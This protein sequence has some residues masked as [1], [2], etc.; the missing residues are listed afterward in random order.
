MA[1]AALAAVLSPVCSAGWWAEND[2][3]FG[4]GKLQHDSL[5][6]YR[7]SANG[8]FTAGLNAGSLLRDHHPHLFPI[9]DRVL[10]PTT[11]EELT[12]HDVVFLGLPH[13]KSAEIAE[14]LPD[15][16]VII[17]CGA[18]FRLSRSAT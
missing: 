18:D 10:G 13:G 5:T 14:A 2:Y 6:L 9:A 7:N 4:S 17:D 11:I 12:G 8:R 1:A 16:T 3:T 15:S